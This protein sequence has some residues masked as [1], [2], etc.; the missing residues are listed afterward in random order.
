[1]SQ[2]NVEIGIQGID[3]IR[4]AVNLWIGAFD[5][6]HADVEEWIDA[7]DAVV[8]AVHWHGQ[9]KATGISVD[10]HQFDIYE[11]SDGKIVR[12]TLGYRSRAEALEAAGLSE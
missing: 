6:L 12:A 11:F 1:M 8:G 5:E 9:G 4:D 10:S 3:R 2:E 7:G